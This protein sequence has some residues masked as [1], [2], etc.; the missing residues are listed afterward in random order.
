MPALEAVGAYAIDQD[1]C[2]N[3]WW[4]RRECPAGAILFFERPERAHWIDAEQCIDCGICARVCPMRCIDRMPYRHDPER[5]AAAQRKAK[6]FARARR[7]RELALLEASASENPMI[8]FMRRLQE[9]GQRNGAAG[10]APGHA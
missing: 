7:Q 6:D 8:E 5:L 2:M 10:G 9:L 1:R 3:C 4:C